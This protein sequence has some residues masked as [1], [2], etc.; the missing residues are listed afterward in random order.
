[1]DVFLLLML[2][3]DKGGLLYETLTA[4]PLYMC[5]VESVTNYYTRE[6]WKKN[7]MV[8]L[9]GLP[10]GVEGKYEIP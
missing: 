6:E 7:W 5:D 2:A 1:M 10:E 8:K 4:Y 9:M 3:R